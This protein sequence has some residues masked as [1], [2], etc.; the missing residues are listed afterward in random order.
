MGLA[1]FV[2]VCCEFQWL[3]ASL[4]QQFSDMAPGGSLVQIISLY[5]SV[6]VIAFLLLC[7]LG[8]RNE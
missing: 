1:R 4:T 2:Y 6:Q 7:K 8:M 5:I 3:F